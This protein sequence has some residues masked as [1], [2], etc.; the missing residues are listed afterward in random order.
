MQWAV[1]L[2]LLLL[3]NDP[4]RVFL[5]TDHPNGGC[6]WR[7]PEIIQLLMDAEFRKEQVKKL[8]A[9]AQKRIVLA[10]LDREYTLYEIA[11]ITSAGP[12]RALGLTQKGHLGV[13]ADADVA[14]Y[15]TKPDDG[16]LF[17]LS[18]LRDQGRRD[19]GR[20]GRDPRGD[21]GPRVHRPPR[22]RR[23]DRGLPPPA[24]PEGLHDVVR[25]LSGGD[26]A[27]STAGRPAIDRL[28][29]DSW[30]TM[31]TLTLKEQPTVPLEAEV[32]SPDVTATLTN[33][34]I[35]ALPVYLGKR[36]RRL[37]DFFASRARPAT[38]SRFAAMRRKVKWIGR[39]MTRG[40]HH[41]R[42]QRRHA[43]GRLHEGR[44]DRGVRATPPTGSA[45]R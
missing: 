23:A 41:D 10:D 14:I 40:P 6:F 32:L 3:I 2:E 28:P 39:G 29:S 5:T 30:S 26:R 11:I 38:S 24:V 1:G 15:P 27:A 17:T 7:Y 21:R 42:R 12:A 9:E 34:E 18:A 37:D 35:R 45:P 25:E 13:G 31:I 19:R 33:D 20:G 36:Q 8:P 16:L 44:H 22:L 4:W 43:P